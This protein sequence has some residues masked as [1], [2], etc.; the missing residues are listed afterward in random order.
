MIG[1]V[2]KVAIMFKRSPTKNDDVL[3]KYVQLD[4]GKEISLISDCK[5]RYDSIIFVLYSG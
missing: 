3:Q 5:T 4:F 2:R 1:K